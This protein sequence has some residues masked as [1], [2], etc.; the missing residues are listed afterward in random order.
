MHSDNLFSDLPTEILI[1]ILLDLDVVAI[2]HLSKTNRYLFETLC[3]PQIW[4]YAANLNG[5][6][7]RMKQVSKNTLNHLFGILN[8]TQGLEAED[9]VMV[10]DREL[11]DQ[12][13]LCMH[14]ANN[15]TYPKE[16][17]ISSS[18][19]LRRGSDFQVQIFPLFC[20]VKQDLDFQTVTDSWTSYER[21]SKESKLIKASVTVRD[22]VIQFNMY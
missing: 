17:S 9:V 1:K 7:S 4:N 10:V 6:V 21:K 19:T 14:D 20:R 12:F 11:L 22:T 8:H 16:M 2:I 15:S 5:L 3:K 18:L 13:K